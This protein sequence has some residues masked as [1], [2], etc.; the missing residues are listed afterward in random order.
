MSHLHGLPAFRDAFAALPGAD[1]AVAPLYAEEAA[2]TAFD[3]RAGFEALPAAQ[4]QR[5][6]A[7]AFAGGL[8]RSSAK[9]QMMAMCKAK[10]RVERQQLL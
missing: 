1:G 2:G 5:L 3:M 8:R 9:I 6:G 10:K 4:R 7:S